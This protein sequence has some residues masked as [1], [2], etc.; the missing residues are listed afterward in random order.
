ML[1]ELYIFQAEGSLL[2][3]RPDFVPNI[4]DIQSQE[5]LWGPFRQSLLEFEISLEL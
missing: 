2:H 3:R 5:V 1:A 4:F